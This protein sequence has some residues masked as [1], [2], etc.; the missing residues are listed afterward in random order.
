MS[1]LKQNNMNYTGLKK[2]LNNQTLTFEQ[3]MEMLDMQMETYKQSMEF[4][5]KLRREY[6]YL[7]S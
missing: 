5:A 2:N 1:N 6:E 3:E 4:N 7:R